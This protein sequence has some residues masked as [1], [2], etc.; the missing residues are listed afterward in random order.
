MVESM[1]QLFKYVAFFEGCSIQ[2]VAVCVR[3]PDMIDRFAKKIAK[4]AGREQVADVR[5]WLAE[6]MKI[7]FKPHN[8]ADTTVA[9]S[10]RCE[11]TITMSGSLLLE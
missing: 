8:V 5:F 3:C 9:G 2:E 7:L 4:K 10:V 11:S 6:T 1:R